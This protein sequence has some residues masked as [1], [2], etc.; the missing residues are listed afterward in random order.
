M[1]NLIEVSPAGAIRTPQEAL[2][3][4][5][6]LQGK[7]VI[8]FRE[9]VYPLTEPLVLNAAHSNTIWEAAEGEPVVFSG[10]ETV[11][12]W[13]R[14][15]INGKT[16]W[17]VQLAPGRMIR[18]LW[19]D[20]NRRERAGFP[21]QG[22]WHFTGKEEH[23]A[24]QFW[25]DGPIKAR[26]QAGQ[27][28]KFRN[29][30]DVELIVREWWDEN[31]FRIAE[32][33]EETCEVTFN[34]RS[35]RDLAGEDNRYARYKLRNVYEALTEP[36][37]WYYDRKSGKLHYIPL[38]QES[39]ETTEIRISE[40]PFLLKIEGSKD[41]P[42][43]NIRFENIAFRHCG[44][45]LPEDF[46]DAYQA[47]WNI[48]GAITL[49]HAVS[50]GFHH[51]EIAHT[52]CTGVRISAGAK[53]TTLDSCEIHDLGGPGVIIMPEQEKGPR[54]EEPM[55][56]DIVNCRI[57]NGGLDYAESC[58]LLI[59]NSGEN[60]IVHNEI[61]NFPYT[62]IS[63]GWLWGFLMRESRAG[64]NRI[65]Y[66]HIHHINDGILSDNGGIYSLGPQPGSTI[67]G[68]CIHDIGDY[69]YG[70]QGIYLDEG[71]SGIEVRRNL[72]KNTR[73]KPFNIHFAQF[74]DVSGNIFYGSEEGITS[75]GRTDLTYHVKTV[76]NIYIPKGSTLIPAPENAA[77]FSFRECYIVR[78]DPS[79]LP[80][81]CSAVSLEI[82]PVSQMPKN[83]L[84]GFVPFD[85]SQAG[86]QPEFHLPE[87]EEKSF[88]ETSLEDLKRDHSGKKLDFTFIIRNTGKKRI[89]AEYQ[90]FAVDTVSCKKVFCGKTAVSIPADSTV[91]LP[92]SIQL[93]E[94]PEGTHQCWLEASSPETECYSSAMAFFLPQPEKKIP[95]YPDRR[96]SRPAHVLPMHIEDDE[97]NP[98]FDGFGF[99]E[100]DNLHLEGVVRD[101][102]IMV[103]PSC[104]WNGSVAELFLAVSPDSQIMQYA[105]V[106]PYQDQNRDVR[107]L[108]ATSAPSVNDMFYQAELREDGWSFTLIL[109]MKK[110]GLD[111][112][113]F[114]FDLIV[115]TSSTIKMH[116]YERKALWGS[117]MDY[118]NA[119]ELVPLSAE[120]Q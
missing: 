15:Q 4:S 47:A 62:G 74:A 14:T 32:V 57:Y 68:N 34:K 67:I 43:K 10:G 58:G 35:L 100:G 82:D 52:T 78:E 75:Y 23:A 38:K 26:F 81:G 11:R 119:N 64:H 80:A 55:A 110:R 5:A 83:P 39:P 107:R 115:R 89:D 116:P 16:A 114:Y 104:I 53:R 69:F 30:E 41:S 27:I 61:S 108:G 102:K 73:G 59:G 118:A 28:R 37:E 50:C 21:K 103:N 84:S 33:N 111:A 87:R 31:H 98:M 36:G 95:A 93:P 45:N 42:A 1:Q 117:L 90:F 12:G 29:L 79:D 96:S 88:L 76:H 65:E 6:K 113:K 49:R 77:T 71:S 85:V 94:F 86:V 54:D 70:G 46:P 63:L 92:Q 72:V 112:S 56:S 9:G 60:R 101:P 25:G 22:V 3:E 99:L 44:W 20:G 8:R 109:P 91:S 24:S 19:A 51:C 18:G 120:H 40:I 17:T 2:L 7:A 66:N 106:P 97:H 48:P 105:L 13:K